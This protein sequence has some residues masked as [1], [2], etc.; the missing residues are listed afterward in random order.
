LLKKYFTAALA[1][2][3]LVT[4]VGVSCTKLDT[5]SQGA[6]ILVVDNIN[7]FA[8]T[9]DL[10]QTTQGIF[11][12][13]STVL[14]KTESHV[15]GR[16]DN[17]PYFGKTE[18]AIYVQFKPTFYPFYFGN[19]GDTVKF[20]TSGNASLAAGLDSAFICLSYKGAYGD[21]TFATN[22]PQTFEVTQIFDAEFF[23]KTDTLRRL[24][25][26]PAISTGSN[27]V[28]GSAVIT[29][30][31]IAA[32]S[33]LNKGL[34]KDSI[35]NQIRIKLDFAAASAIFYGQD[36]TPTGTNNGFY[37][38]SF[39]RAR[40]N[41]FAITVKPQGTGNTLYYVNIAEAATRLEF[42]YHKIKAGVKDTV[43]QSFQMFPN[44]I[45]ST[46]A[47]SSSANYLKRDYGTTAVTQ[48]QT[49]SNPFLYLQTSPGTFVN[50]KVPQLDPGSPKAV[51]K[52][53]HRAFL[54]VEQDPATNS[55]DDKYTA[56]PYLYLDLK[57]KTTTIPQRY[58][59]MYYDLSNQSYDPDASV[60]PY[61]FPGNNVDLNLFGGAALKRYDAITGLPFY[62]YEINITRYVQH[63]VTNKL[64][65]Y[66]LRLYAPYNF[67][68]GQYGGSQFSIPYYNPVAVG[69]MR[70]GSAVNANH[71]MKIVVIYS[72]V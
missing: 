25:F 37:N 11:L 28:I 55:F 16:I 70:V 56:P 64:Y 72:K 42:H 52:I 71:K 40:N 45:G 1:T 59:P 29:P 58:K 60:F 51:N 47:T 2:A 43:V 41:G 66:D 23:K 26:T 4:I 8:D 32:Y 61:F 18:A 35:N 24:N 44:P 67:Y 54:I 33:R 39:F 48:N 31:K 13:D 6:D 7:T 5:T 20:G 30:Q 50:I 65:N 63:I 15:I 10:L 14:K 21:T 27:Q 57:E 12:D 62:R 46:I 17:D 49:V 69:R 3:L 53:V 38:D 68:Y 36:S 34:I 9:L 22:A 19:A